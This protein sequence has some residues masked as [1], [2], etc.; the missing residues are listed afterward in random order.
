MNLNIPRPTRT[1]LYALTVL[2][3]PSLADMIDACD[4]Y[5]D[6][7]RAGAWTEGTKAIILFRAPSREV[8]MAA[9]STMGGDIPGSQL[10]VGTGVHRTLVAEA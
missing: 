1:V 3:S 7:T 10:H 5:P 4:A 6:I 9:A 2:G 8:A